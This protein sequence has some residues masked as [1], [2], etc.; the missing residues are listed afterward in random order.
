MSDRGPLRHPS[1]PECQSWVI[2]FWDERDR[3][4]F[5]DLTDCIQRRGPKR[6][7]D[8]IEQ[9]KK[10]LSNSDDVVGV[11]FYIGTHLPERTTLVLSPDTQEQ[12]IDIL[13]RMAGMMADE[14]GIVPWSQ[15][16]LQL[17]AIRDTV[18]TT[19]DELYPSLGFGA[20]IPSH[21]GY[22]EASADW[23]A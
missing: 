13:H 9:F 20:I 3:D 5:D 10:A 22:T 23:I 6:F 1:L 21:Q 2:P 19:D 11:R 8:A 4:E 12:T 17:S 15:I 18:S 7:D 16:N 14:R